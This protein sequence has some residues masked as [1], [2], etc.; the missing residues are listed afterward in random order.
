[1]GR[2]CTVCIHPD[3]I[4]IEK[5]SVD[6]LSSS[7]LADRYNLN[8]HAILRHLK[9]HT[10]IRKPNP[11]AEQAETLADMLQ[12]LTVKALRVIDAQLTDAQSMTTG[13]L[14]A[15]N[16]LKG[17]LSTFL[18]LI[19]SREEKRAETADT[20]MVRYFGLH[21]EARSAYLR[22]YKAESRLIRAPKPQAEPYTG[23]QGVQTDVQQAN[24]AP[25]VVDRAK[26][27]GKA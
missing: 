20:A 11:D 5:G 23:T 13:G 10:A 24:G 22:W 2:S 18:E 7:M 8:H 4:E 3:K 1:M 14:G 9:Y 6:G 19:K 15:V 25:I 26:E 16:A 17:Y 12:T 21:P 27:A